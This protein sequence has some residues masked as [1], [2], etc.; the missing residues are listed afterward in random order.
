MGTVRGGLT[1]QVL[2]QWPVTN[3]LGAI[4]AQYLVVQFSTNLTTPTARWVSDI[5]VDWYPRPPPLLTLPVS[6]QLSGQTLVGAP[7]MNDITAHL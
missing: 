2:N 5:S 7:G 3:T 1:N 4:S 6:L